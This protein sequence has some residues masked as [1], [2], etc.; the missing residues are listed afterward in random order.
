[1]LCSKIDISSK[2]DDY[3]QRR[4]D[5]LVWYFPPL[6][7]AILESQIVKLKH[8]L[9][10][11]KMIPYYMERKYAIMCTYKKEGEAYAW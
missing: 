3:M 7:E 4:E 10:S 9:V 11:R 5:E 8:K 2:V 6:Y 1:M